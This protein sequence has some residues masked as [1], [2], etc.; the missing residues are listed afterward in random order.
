MID[1]DPGTEAERLEE[2]HAVDWGAG[3]A[4]EGDDENRE[5]ELSSGQRARKQSAQIR[6]DV[7]KAAKTGQ[8]VAC[9][10]CSRAFVKASYQQAF[11]CNKGSG[12]C[13]D[14]FHNMMNPR[15][16]GLVL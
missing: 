7:A 3:A 1:D 11:C 12:N 8:K 10:Y 2:W 6:Y 4:W 13:K 9:G 15:G 16:K 14:S 5:R